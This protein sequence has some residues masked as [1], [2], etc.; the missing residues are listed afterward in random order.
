MDGAIDIASFWLASDKVVL[1]ELDAEKNESL[2]YAKGPAQ[3]ARTK[4]IVLMNEGSASASEIV[5]GA[6]QDH[7]LATVVGEKSFGKGSVQ[8]LLDLEGGGALKITIAK[9]LTPNGRTI[10]KQGLEADVK[11]ERTPEDYD[12]DRDPQMDKA[13]ELAGS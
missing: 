5:A 2:Y 12:N 7:K 10:H 4:T 8:D 13:L 1:K 9:W 3:L 11:V 6:L